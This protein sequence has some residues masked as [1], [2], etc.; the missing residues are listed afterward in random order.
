MD[1][2]QRRDQ[3]DCGVRALV[4]L[5]IARDCSVECFMEL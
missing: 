5:A 2:E 1:A 4:A 3:Q